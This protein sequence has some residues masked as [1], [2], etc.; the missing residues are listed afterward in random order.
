[1]ESAIVW[2][3]RGLRTTITTRDHVWHA[4]E[5]LDV[6]GGTNTAATPM[7][8]VMGALG[9]CIA[10]TVHLYANRKNWPLEKVEV[11]VE[12]ER[13]AGSEYPAYKGDAQYVH[14]VRELVTLYGEQLTPEQHSTLMEIAKKC[15][16]RRLL[17]TPTF[18]VESEAAPA[19]PV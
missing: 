13:F 3:D 11:H 9:S 5:P 15:P 2:T 14:E 18:F 8:Q 6:A 1:M 10:I 7:E 17:A 16:V 19:S 4:D 12:V